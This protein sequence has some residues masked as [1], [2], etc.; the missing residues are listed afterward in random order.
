MTYCQVKKPCPTGTSD[1]KSKINLGIQVRLGQQVGVKWLD[2]RVGERTKGEKSSPSPSQSYLTL[3]HESPA[4][5]NPIPAAT[6][7]LDQWAWASQYICTWA[8]K[9]F[10]SGSQILVLTQNSLW[11]KN[12]NSQFQLVPA[13]SSLC[14]CGLNSLVALSLIRNA[15]S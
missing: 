1:W 15:N 10:S 8:L 5:P 7:S 13:E 2:Y 12:P 3:L 11:R 6:S 9:T 14:F 4:C